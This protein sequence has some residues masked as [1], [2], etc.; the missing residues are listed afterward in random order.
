MFGA[1]SSSVAAGSP[2]PTAVWVQPTRTGQW[3]VVQQKDGDSHFLHAG[4]QTA[5]ARW[6]WFQVNGQ[7]QAVGSTLE[8]LYLAFQDGFVYRYSS[9]KGRV[10]K[11]PVRVPEEYRLRALTGGIDRK[12]LYAIGQYSPKQPDT[13]SAAATSPAGRQVIF[14][15]VRGEWQALAD[16]PEMV[17]ETDAVSFVPDVRQIDLLIQKGTRRFA[18]WV[19]RNGAWS[20]PN[21]FELDEAVGRHWLGV[22]S[23]A[24]PLYLAACRQTDGAARLDLYSIGEQGDVS[25]PVALPVRDGAA[26]HCELLDVAFTASHLELVQLL[27]GGEARLARYDYAGQAVGEPEELPASLRTEPA[28]EPEITNLVILVLLAFLFFLARAF[29]PARTPEL[30]SDI[31]L[32][33]YWR[34]TLAAV[35]DFLPVSLAVSLIWYDRFNEL[36]LQAGSFSQLVEQ[37]AQDSRLVFAS[38]A[39][40]IGYGLYCMITELIWSATP[41]KLL[42]GLRV[43]SARDPA[44]PASVLQIVVRNV[45]KALELYSPPLFVVMLM[46]L[47]LTSLRQ[48]TGDLLAGTIVVQPAPT[49]E[50][51]PHE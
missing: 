27:A 37:S 24:S 50:A 30:P 36:Y 19:F 34:R 13:Q 38:L 16:L 44:S 3:L 46:T 41:G 1:A 33:E 8:Y 7:A 12:R 28:R 35:I 43:R 49:G 23:A 14:E 51:P 21:R 39:T 42:F 5:Q 6:Q 26:D 2:E 25:D 9:E 47:F 48:R 29:H 40:V 32:A 22:S 10:S 45:A 18:H 11:Y 17:E 4:Y 15:Y 20:G 31:A